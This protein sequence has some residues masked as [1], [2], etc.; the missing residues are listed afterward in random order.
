MGSW[1][2][3]L[4]RSFWSKLINVLLKVIGVDNTFRSLISHIVNLRD[5]FHLLVSHAVM[6]KKAITSDEAHALLK[7]ERLSL[8]TTL[9]ML[10]TRLMGGR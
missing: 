5:T 1:E 8:P 6:L 4:P 9:S 7:V 10:L 2:E 3:W